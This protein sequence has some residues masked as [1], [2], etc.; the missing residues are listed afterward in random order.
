MDATE[1]IL[2][3]F[4]LEQNFPNPFNS[5]TTIYYTLVDNTNVK[6]EIIDINGRLINTLV[7]ENQTKGLKSIT[8]DGK[9]QFGNFA[10]SGVYFYRLKTKNND[11]TKKLVFIK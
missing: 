5:V 1:I 9:D 4:N 3:K 8:W 6:F 7:N 11:K 10:K 2:D